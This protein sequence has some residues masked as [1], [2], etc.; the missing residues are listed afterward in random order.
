MFVHL[1]GKRHGQSTQVDSLDSTNV[2]NDELLLVFVGDEGRSKFFGVSVDVE[3]Q[4][5]QDGKPDILGPDG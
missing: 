4:L 5:G 1:M 3:A 2:V